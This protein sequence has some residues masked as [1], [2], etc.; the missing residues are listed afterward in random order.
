MKI[1]I[2]GSGKVG[3]ALR[4]SAA[5]AGHSVTLLPARARRRPRLVADLV[6]LAVR[7]GAVAALAEELARS[8]A[9][10]QRAHVVHVAGSLGPDVLA[11]LRGRC[12]GVAQA[13][14]LLSFASLRHSPDLHGA[15]L[16]VAG[17]GGAVRRARALARSLGMVP[18]DLGSLDPALYHAAAALTANGAAALTAAAADLLRAAGASERDAVRALA[19]LLGSVASN[20]AE[21]GLPGALT[22]PIRRGDDATVRRHLLALERQPAETERLYRAL[23]LLQLK[24]AEALGEA[25]P[26][27]LARVGRELRR[28]SKRGARRR[29][30]LR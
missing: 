13:H 3:R 28:P 30:A 18:R 24:L 9:V 29:T 19:P 4:R 15:S 21:L 17:D 6:I 14:P 20:L 12:A 22:G 10:D 25:D 11:S 2:L 27:A 8:D 5:A 16:F 26:R 23:G 1:V 7:D